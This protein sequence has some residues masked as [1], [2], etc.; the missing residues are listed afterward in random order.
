[1][2]RW[3]L[4]CPDCHEDFTH[5]E[6]AKTKLE[7]YFFDRKP[8]FPVDGLSME[9]PNCHKTSLFQRHELTYRAN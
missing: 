6:I 3:V 7:D 2:S 9:C 8:E 5:T 1:M 4:N